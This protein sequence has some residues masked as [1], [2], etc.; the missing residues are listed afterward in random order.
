[1]AA[2][3]GEK[4]ILIDLIEHGA[5]VDIKTLN[6]N[7]ALHVAA[8]KGKTESIEALLEHDRQLVHAANDEGCTALH[9]ASLIGHSQ[10][11]SLLIKHGASL[12][13]LGLPSVVPL[14]PGFP[15]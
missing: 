3:L 10:S 12:V 1:M 15:L 2:A 11:V 4:S 13:L 7:T 9:Q 14:S 8:D 6:G 5:K